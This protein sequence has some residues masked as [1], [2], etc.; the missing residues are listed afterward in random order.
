MKGCECLPDNNKTMS[1]K[2]GFDL[3]M[4]IS[5]RKL[6]VLLLHQFHL[7]HKATEAASNMCSMIEKD[8]LFIRTAQLWFN[9]FKNSNVELDD[10]PRS[11]RL[12]KVNMN[13]LK[14]RIE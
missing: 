1:N 10:L 3:E 14:Q 12:L 9:R 11:G 7:D 13:V 8:V 6:Q 2:A 4:E 5:R